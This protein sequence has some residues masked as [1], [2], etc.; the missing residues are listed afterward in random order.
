MQNFSYHT[1]TNFSDGHNTVEEMVQKGSELGLKEIGISDH[2]IVHKDIK[3]S[4][5]YVEYESSRKMKS[6]NFSD[7][8]ERLAPRNE[9]IYKAGE[10]YGIKT[11]VGFEVDYFNYAGWE[12]NLREFLSKIH[13]DYLV[14]GNHFLCGDEINSVQKVYD[15]SKNMPA[16][17]MPDLQRYIE[18]HFMTVAKAIN[19]GLFDFLAHFDYVKKIDGY[20]KY[21]FSSAQSCIIKALKNTQTACEISTK[22]LRRIGE[23]YPSDEILNNL[24]KNE[25][26]MLI[27][28]D[29]H[30]VDEIGYT[31]DKAEEKLLSAGNKNWFCLK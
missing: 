16:E 21:D 24:I 5:G 23:F 2:L 27:S 13:Y 19:T 10:K 30:D 22:G 1:H 8:Y 17:I 29:A 11:Y 25:I 12:D 7:A 4:T 28:D 15:I 18:N 26:P 31:F 9:K 20:K 6:T 14:S 3:I